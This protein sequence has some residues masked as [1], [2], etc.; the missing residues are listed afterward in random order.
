[1]YTSDTIWKEIEDGVLIVPEIGKAYIQTEQEQSDEQYL[2]N[3]KD[4]VKAAKDAGAKVVKFQTHTVEDEQLD[5]TITA[6]HFSGSDRYSWV[7]RLTKTAP[8]SFWK[9]VKKYCDEL[10][11]LFF[12][13]P[14]SKGAAKLLNEVGVD[15]WKVASSDILDFVLL[16]YLASTEKPIILSSGMSTTEEL[17]KSIQFLKKRTNKIAL[18]HCVSKYPCPVEEL[19]LDTIEY[20]KERYN[21]PVGFSDHSLGYDAAIVAIKKGATIIEKHITLDRGLWGSDHKISQTPS[22]LK[23]MINAINNHEIR[24]ETQ[25]GKGVKEMDEHEK[26]FRP[27]FRK[28]LM[29][30]QDISEGTVIT[31][32]MLYAMRP[33]KYAKGLASEE[34]EQVLGKKTTKDLKKY[35]PYTRDSI[36]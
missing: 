23:N 17:D 9:E 21:I 8:I 11:M 24:D 31:K 10:D 32:E 22:E 3:A 6:P 18:L 1:M 15:I 25:Y 36:I 5:V 26:S 14:M 19:Y 12:S 28:S 20:Y 33:Q 16:G 2:Q 27:V 29:A 7:T 30:G 13:T 35:D 4:L 34:Y